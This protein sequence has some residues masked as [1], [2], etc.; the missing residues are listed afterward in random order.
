MAPVHATS[1]PRSR[2]PAQKKATAKYFKT[3]KG[4]AAQKKYRTS[5]KGRQTMYA[6]KLKKIN[7][8]VKTTS[9]ASIF[10][11]PAPAVE[12]SKK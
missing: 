3:A 11:T 2:Y 8:E 12:E 9:I 5:D 1:T 4:K 6:N 7:K 10:K